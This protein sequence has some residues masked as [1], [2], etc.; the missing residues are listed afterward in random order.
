[1]IYDLFW[2]LRTGQAIWEEKRIL[3]EDIFSHGGGA[4]GYTEFLGQ[5]YFYAWEH[6]GGDWGIT[7][8]TALLLGGG[9][10]AVNRL[11]RSPSEA[12]S[13]PKWL[14]T[15]I[16][17][18]EYLSTWGI[19]LALALWA[20]T[21]RYR[22]GPKMEMFSFIGLA[23]AM[24]MVARLDPARPKRF[25]VLLSGLLVLWGNLHRGGTLALLV[26][27][28]YGVS[29]FVSGDGKRSRIALASFPI[30]AG[31]LCLNTA[32]YQYLVAS[33]DLVGRETFRTSFPEWAPMNG[34]FL[35]FSPAF[36]LVV[37]LW[38]GRI[39]LRR[40]LTP[41]DLIAGAT[42]LLALN[43]VRFAPFF[44]IA[45]VPNLAR[46]LSEGL[47]WAER[48][49]DPWVREEIFR[50]LTLVLGLVL[51]AASH[52]R[53]TPPSFLGVGQVYWR[54]PVEGARF[55]QNNLPPGKMWNSFNLGGYLIHALGPKTK[56][57]IDGRND[58]VYSN[59]FFKKSRLAVKH[60]EA[61]EELVKTQDLNFAVVECRK[62]QCDKPLFLH[63]SPD[64]VPV[65]LGENSA[66]LVRDIAR[67][68]DYLRKHGMTALRPHNFLQSL[69]A[70]PR[71]PDSKGFERDVLR[72]VRH[73]PLSMRA[74][75]LA[76]VV[77]KRQGRL[78]S[79]QRERDAFLILS[80]ERNSSI[81][82]P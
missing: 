39:L 51:L 31:A 80:T 35:L 50:A 7:L 56:V 1:M 82:P 53:M 73:A 54:L 62:F 45:A 61:F 36:V 25:V 24:A 2:H 71:R 6:L 81:P 58:T 28:I 16:S 60:A 5:L 8:G 9:A 78:E 4:L 21:C 40:Q 34:T 59:Q 69:D 49:A 32:G 27:G 64:W 52:I 37:V 63:A 72:N 47:R 26:L 14:Q 20:S 33:F 3:T 57:F 13:F 23:L 75:F 48:R 22:F 38:G 44:A 67:N 18:P 42:L 43:A 65:F 70:F 46:G 11:A 12:L 29:W 19:G 66:I 74:H 79:Y 15:K 55:L 68:K 77:H 30:A 41:A 10:L 17:Y 76:A